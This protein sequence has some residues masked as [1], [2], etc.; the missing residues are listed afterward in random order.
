M[1]S[2]VAACGDGRGEH[3]PCGPALSLARFGQL[4]SGVLG[5]RRRCY[6]QAV[7]SPG[8]VRGE[9]AVVQQYCPLPLPW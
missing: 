8:L 2:D 9:A 4:R 7:P 6:D 1:I 5:V 3:A